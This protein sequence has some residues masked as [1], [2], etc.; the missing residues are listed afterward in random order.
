MLLSVMRSCAKELDREAGA[1]SSQGPPRARI[2]ISRDR[3]GTTE[4]LHRDYFA[5]QPT[6]PDFK[7]KRRYRM[8][9]Q[10]FERIIAGIRDCTINP[11]PAQFAYFRHAYDAT[12]RQSFNIY[13]KCTSAL[14]QLVYGTTGD[15]RDEYLHMSEQT[16]L[17]CLDNFF[18]CVTDLYQDVYLRKPNAR[19]IQRIYETH[20]T[21]HGSNNDINV[22]NRSSL[23]DSIKNGSAPP[24]PFTVNGHDYTHGYY[25]A[26]GIYPDWATLIKAY[27]SPTDD[28]SAKFIRFQE[29]ARKDFERTFGVLQGRFNILRVPGRAWRAK[30][31]HCIL[32]CCV[33]LHNM[34]QE[35]MVLL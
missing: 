2:Y 32:Y 23:F 12:G 19:D 25:L 8:E 14:R 3:E 5:E 30:K 27:S 33:L 13:Q 18:L 15:T 31:M 28:P 20:E 4:R 10:L 21:R 24:S 17:K 22:L 34:I 35:D 26:D 1:G 9:P 16:S 29:S 11:L 6:F 7:F